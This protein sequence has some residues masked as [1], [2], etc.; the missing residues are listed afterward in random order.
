MPQDAST[1]L[2]ELQ[3][4]QPV[5]YGGDRVAHVSAELAA[6]FRPGDQLRVVEATGELLHVPAAEA[7]IAADAVSRAVAAFRAMISRF[8][9]DFAARLESEEIWREIARVNAVDVEKA[10]ARGRS[11]TRLVA[12]DKLR[13][14]M[15]DGLRGWIAT[16]S[17]RG[18]AS[19]KS[20]GSG[21]ADSSGRNHARPSSCGSGLR[22]DPLRS[23]TGRET[24]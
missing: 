8:Y 3:A 13:L 14:D 18:L 4:G 19:T 21:E 2:T 7:E 5:L 9:E 23:R 24:R 16:E 15:I 11:T 17:Q 12:S 10:Q 20:A 22:R 1:R 6:A